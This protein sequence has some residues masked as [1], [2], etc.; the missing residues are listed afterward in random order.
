MSKTCYRW[1][2][3]LE[4]WWQAWPWPCCTFPKSS[5]AQCW[6]WDRLH[7]HRERWNIYILPALLLLLPTVLYSIGF[8]VSLMCKDVSALNRILRKQLKEQELTCRLEKNFSHLTNFT[9]GEFANQERKEK[10]SIFIFISIFMLTSFNF[11][12]HVI[13]G[14]S[15]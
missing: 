3:H 13:M 14:R 8:I 9:Y 4:K 11:T 12:Y 7:S 10:A 15:L 2:D 6:L 5:I 1:Q